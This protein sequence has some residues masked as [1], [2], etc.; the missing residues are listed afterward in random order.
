MK[1]LHRAFLSAAPSAVFMIC[2]QPAFS[3]APQPPVVPKSGYE[4]EGRP[5]FVIHYD[6]TSLAWESF[7]ARG[8]PAGLK[9]RLLSRSAS[10]GAVSQITY[11]P[12]GWSRPA[13]YHDV[14]TEIV[15]L[16]GDL[17]IGASTGAGDENLTRYS[18][19]YLPAGVMQG[20]LK[21][22][23]GAVLL[24][25]WK[26][27]PNFVAANRDKKGAR[28]NARVRDWNLFKSPWYV[29]KPFPDYRV[30]GNFSGAI[31]K[32]LRHDPDTGEMTWMTFGAGIPAP[33]RQLG[34][35]GGGYE[36]HPSF[37]EYFFP[38][39]SNDTVIGECLEQ[40][41]TQVKYGDQSYWWRPGGVGH[42]GPT[43]HGDGTAG[44]NI[45]IVRTGVVLWAD[46]VTDCSYE[47]GLEFTGSGFRTY[48]YD[49]DKL[50][51]K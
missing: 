31:H 42:G 1:S 24:N 16:E 38:E 22:R 33:S 51:Q 48:K 34:N 40:G 28:V 17:S 23:Q 19:S 7:E 35:F 21:S 30:G 44:Y 43:G 32:L 39:K 25:W 10:M 2:S 15:V 36:V 20:P 37:E 6:A 27:E 4:V 47:T 18:Y 8:M 46:Y 26:G 11:V 3:Q 9:R 41:L 13:G 50:K 12:A 49:R 14:D 5:G 29:G 45:S